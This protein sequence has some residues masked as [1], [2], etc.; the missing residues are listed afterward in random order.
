M[1]KITDN[2]SFNFIDRKIGPPKISS[3]KSEEEQRLSDNGGVEGSNK[4]EQS[5]EGGKSIAA[6]YRDLYEQCLKS[7]SSAIPLNIFQAFLLV[8]ARLDIFV[9]GCHFEEHTLGQFKKMPENKLQVILYTTVYH[10]LFCLISSFRYFPFAIIDPE[11]A[12]TK[13][14]WKMKK[15]LKTAGNFDEEAHCCDI[16]TFCTKMKESQSEAEVESLLHT[17]YP[18]A[19]YDEEQIQSLIDQIKNAAVVL[20]KTANDYQQPVQEGKQK[21]F[22][23]HSVVLSKTANAYQQF[24]Q[25]GKEEEPHRD[26]TTVVLSKTA[27]AKQQFPQEGKEEEPQADRDDDISYDEDEEGKEKDGSSKV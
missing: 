19:S 10:E 14:M 16:F 7:C 25:E 9:N 27:N 13:T 22:Q 12:V 21:E 18:S 24:P 11:V 23:G 5:P 26:A 2:I 15:I 6:T 20:S 3:D 17:S 4:S 8:D 1:K